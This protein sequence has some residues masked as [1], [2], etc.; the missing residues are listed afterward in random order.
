MLDQVFGPLP[1]KANEVTEIPDTI[2]KGGT[3]E[4]DMPNPRTVINFGGPGP[5]RNAPDFMAAFVANHIL[6]GGAAARRGSM[7]RFASVAVSPIRSGRRCCRSAIS[8]ALR[9]RQH[10][11]PRRPVRTRRCS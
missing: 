3:A 8:A 2:P 6:G 7:K 5:A 1:A 10:R 4:I 9:L 11:D